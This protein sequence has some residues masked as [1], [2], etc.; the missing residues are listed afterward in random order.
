MKTEE[1]V[2]ELR[3]RGYEPHME[4]VFKNN[5]RGLSDFELVEELRRAGYS[6]KLKIIRFG[7][8]ALSPRLEMNLDGSSLVIPLD[9]N[10]KIAEML[11]QVSTENWNITLSTM[12][13]NYY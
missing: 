11:Y 4:K 2:K 12:K 13:L 6:V 10:P 7:E 1:I 9:N 5:L 3:R 8:Q